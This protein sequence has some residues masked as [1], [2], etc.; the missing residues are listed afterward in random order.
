MD[1]LIQSKF[2]GWY[3]IPSFYNEPLEPAVA[4]LSSKR[5][6]KSFSLLAL[7]ITLLLGVTM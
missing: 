1:F 7:Q 6:A 4:I 2:N 3:T 5:H